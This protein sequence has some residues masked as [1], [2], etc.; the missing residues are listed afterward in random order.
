MITAGDHRRRSSRERSVPKEATEIN[1]LQAAS[2]VPSNSPSSM[3]PPLSRPLSSSG[4][5][6]RGQQVAKR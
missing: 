1:P 6:Q 5:I 2:A 4:G 3:P